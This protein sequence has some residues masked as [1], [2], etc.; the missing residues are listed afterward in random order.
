MDLAGVGADRRPGF[1]AEALSETAEITVDHPLLALAEF[2][3][4][5]AQANIEVAK[6]T[7]NAGATV[8]IGTRRE[9][10]PLETGFDDSLGVSVSVPFGGGVHLDTATTAAARTAANTKAVRAREFR[11]L[12]L[13]MHERVHSLGVIQ[14]SYATALERLEIA[15][16]HQAM[17]ESAYES[18]EIELLDLLKIKETAIVARRLKTQLEIDKKRQTALYNQAIGELP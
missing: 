1:V 14:E 8:L 7:G 16:R 10:M 4:E 2:A 13:D 9:R 12:T 6:R 18:G 3:V 5:R 11:M 15:E 17:G